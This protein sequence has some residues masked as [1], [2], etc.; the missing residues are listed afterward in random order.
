MN[1]ENT[2]NPTSDQIDEL[3][4]VEA[5]GLKEIALGVGAAAVLSG[6]GAG[7]AL[8][9]SG[10]AIEPPGPVVATHVQHLEQGVAHSLKG[11]TPQGPPDMMANT[12]K[13]VPSHLPKLRHTVPVGF[14][15]NKSTSNSP[16]QTD[17]VQ[18]V[19]KGTQQAVKNTKHGA[20]N[21]EQAVEKS[22][23]PITAT[24]P[25]PAQR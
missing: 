1:A 4:D 12:R 23:T 22:I 25:P 2:Q 14:D 6:G 8:A 3:D 7:I 24:P 11:H 19:E 16:V 17:P 20:Q 13:P 5:H 21:V 15:G 10:G 18:R 9:S